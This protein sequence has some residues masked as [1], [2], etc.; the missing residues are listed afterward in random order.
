MNS[1][2]EP[3]KHISYFD[4]YSKL[5]DDK[6]LF[7][8][9]AIKDFIDIDFDKIIN[10]NLDVNYIASYFQDFISKITNNFAKE[11]QIEFYTDKELYL[12]IINGLENILCKLLY[13]KLMNLIKDDCIINYKHILF[14]KLKHLG[15]DYNKKHL[16]GLIKLIK[17]FSKV[18][19]YF[20]PKEKMT[21]ITDV[22]NYINV[23][24]ANYDRIKLTKFFMYIIIH[25]KVSKVKTQL[26]YCVLFRHK[27][28]L[29]S[30]EDYYLSVAIQAVDL[31]SKLN[32]KNVSMTKEEFEDKTKLEWENEIILNNNTIDGNTIT[33]GEIDNVVNIPVEE[34]YMKYCS[35]NPDNMPISKFENLRHDMKIILKIIESSKHNK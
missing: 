10:D 9:K 19:D 4:F 25:S 5:R 34:L 18:N 16:E 14:V 1:T 12:F 29:T 30:D 21:I 13:S 31:V 15:I 26:L 28:V 8:R 20:T 11:W 2:N 33:L 6:S 23:T 27:T 17:L 24:Y 32:H 22:C 3:N 7:I 35:D